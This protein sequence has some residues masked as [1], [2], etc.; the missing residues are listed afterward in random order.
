MSDD[1]LRKPPSSLSYPEYLPGVNPESILAILGCH[2]ILILIPRIANPR[3]RIVQSCVILSVSGLTILISPGTVS[4]TILVATNSIMEFKF[5]YIQDSKTCSVTHMYTTIKH[6]I[7]IQIKSVIKCNHMPQNWLLQ[8]HCSWYTSW[9][10]AKSPPFH[11]ATSPSWLQLPP[12]R[13]VPSW[14]VAAWQQLPAG[15]L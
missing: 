7:K 6:E 5:K 9:E 8:H 15:S 3:I 12:L 2:Y 13:E 1:T 10:T 14:S 11:K 4:M